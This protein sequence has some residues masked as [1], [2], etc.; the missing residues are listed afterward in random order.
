MKFLFA[1]IMLTSSYL[2]AFYD[3]DSLNGYW[4]KHSAIADPLSLVY[5]YSPEF[6]YEGECLLLCDKDNEKVEA[7]YVHGLRNSQHINIDH[8]L[9]D[10]VPM[11]Y[12]E[13]KIIF[14]YQYLNEWDYG[15]PRKWECPG[16]CEKDPM[17]N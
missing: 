9:I 2:G 5:H 14:P 10:C 11:S 4:I 6:F 15:F 3:D 8:I 13:A 16:N 17:Q 7:F 1:I 12:N